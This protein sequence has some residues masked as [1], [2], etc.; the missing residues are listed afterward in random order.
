VT[1]RLGEEN[2]RPCVSSL[3]SLSGKWERGAMTSAPQRAYTHRV[4]RAGRAPDLVRHEAAS[5]LHTD[6]SLPFLPPHENVI[7]S[8]GGQQ[9]S[10]AQ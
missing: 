5:P 6:S 7:A 9:S 2:P 3:F 10:D 4:E 8:G 1:P